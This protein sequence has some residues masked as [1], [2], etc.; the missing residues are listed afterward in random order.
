M[1]LELVGV[2]WICALLVFLGICVSM[3]RITGAFAK[4]GDG[5]KDFDSMPARFQRAHG[6]L[7]EWVGAFAALAIVSSKI[8]LGSRGFLAEYSGAMV[9]LAAVGLTVHR[10]GMIV[11]GLKHAHP[12]KMVGFMA[13]YIAMAVLG[14][15]CLHGSLFA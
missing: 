7:A 9:M 5:T 14:V 12:V 8:G 4:T 11:F 10:I 13:F 15:R 1:E 2:S 6:N 3:Y